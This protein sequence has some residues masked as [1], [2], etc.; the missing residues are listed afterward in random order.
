MDIVGA[1]FFRT[2]N[3]IR[4]RLGAN[5][6]PIEIPIGKESDFLGTVDLISMRGLIYL[7][8]VGAVSEEREIPSELREEAQQWR[9]KMLEAL[10]EVDDAVMEK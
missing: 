1:D 9:D 2:V 8:D 6:V 3:M 4:T 5:P 10:A 7:D